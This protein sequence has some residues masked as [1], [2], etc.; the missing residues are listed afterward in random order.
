LTKQLLPAD[1]Q[2]V[3][4]ALIAGGFDMKTPLWYYVL[5]EAEVQT[6]GETLGE[7]GS[8]LVA[9]TLIGL[10]KADPKSYLNKGWDPSHA[11]AVKLPD[12]Q[13]MRSILQ[14]FQFAGVAKMQE[15]AALAA[16]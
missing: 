2:N 6:D 14:F 4:E 15:V 13:E 3:R 11:T 1:K 16:D 5:R 12:G 10:I 8:K 9:G 7:L